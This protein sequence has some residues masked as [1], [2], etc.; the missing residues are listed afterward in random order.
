MRTDLKMDGV[1][2][3]S[4]LCFILSQFDTP[5]D[6]T[7]YWKQNDHLQV[8]LKE[9]F[10]KTQELEDSVGER[11]KELAATQKSREDIKDSIEELEGQI[12]E[13]KSWNSRASKGGA[14]SLLKRKRG[15]VDDT[16]GLFQ[17]PLRSYDY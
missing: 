13:A 11:K 10:A 6:V 7:D 3:A 4:N 12:D 9:E 5:Y 14:K 1:Y 15:A 17:C 8:L 16:P 2:N